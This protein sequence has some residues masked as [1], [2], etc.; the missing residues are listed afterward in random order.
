MARTLLETEE[1]SLHPYPV[2]WWQEY[3]LVENLEEKMSSFVTSNCL[4]VVEIFHSVNILSQITIPWIILG[5]AKFATFMKHDHVTGYRTN[6]ENIATIKADIF[7]RPVSNLFDNSNLYPSTLASYLHLNYSH[8]SLQNKPW[9]CEVN[10]LLYPPENYYQDIYRP[11]I[12]TKV[13]DKPIPSFPSLPVPSIK[14][15]VHEETSIEKHTNL[16]R[17]IGEICNDIFLFLSVNK[18]VSQQNKLNHLV[19]AINRALLVRMCPNEWYSDMETSYIVLEDD[20][21]DS[22]KLETLFNKGLP[23]PSTNFRWI[24]EPKVAP[25]QETVFSQMERY[26]VVCVPPRDKLFLNSAVRRIGYGYASIWLDVMQNYTIL[27]Y[28]TWCSRRYE[29]PKPE[30]MKNALA[31][32]L[33]PYLKSQKIFPFFPRDVKSSLRFISCGKGDF[34]S[35]QFGELINVYDKWCWGLIIAVCF[36]LATLLRLPKDSDKSLYQFDLLSPISILLEQCDGVLEKKNFKVATGTFLLMGIVLSNAYRNKNVYNMVAPRHPLAFKYAWE[37]LARN[38]TLYTRVES[39]EVYDNDKLHNVSLRLKLIGGSHRI[40]SESHSIIIIISEVA[41]VM[42]KITDSFIWHSQK[43]THLKKKDETDTEMNLSQPAINSSGVLE[44]AILNPTV[45]QLL[46]GSDAFRSLYNV[47]ESMQMM[48]LQQYLKLKMGTFL[49]TEDSVLF[50]ALRRCKNIALILPDYLCQKYLKTLTSQW[51]QT[52][53]YVGKEV[54]SAV[55]WMF[56]L[57]RGSKYGET[58]MWSRHLLRR[59]KAAHES[60]HWDRWSRLEEELEESDNAYMKTQHPVAAGMSGNIV[61]V[62]ALFMC[63]IGLAIVSFLFEK[64]FGVYHTTNVMK[65]E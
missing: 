40:I 41:S 43:Q 45:E 57:G 59:I 50:E 4:I 34:S 24:F 46:V 63:G 21:T 29:K 36:A 8:L 55:E 6:N 62:F 51:M 9:N 20:S 48:F 49:E 2:E 25:T 39:L 19:G 47:P 30:S 53:V 1:L 61:V 28:D 16:I 37:L 35:L 7:N 60:G 12:S 42:E 27:T 13:P 65:F 56:R 54:Y 64:C 31:L 58:E 5:A 44:R 14:I 22:R 26:L 3:P 18:V 11:K 17:E 38:F 15:F 32:D 33:I 10:L 52:D 23:P